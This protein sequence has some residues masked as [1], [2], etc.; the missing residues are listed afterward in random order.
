MREVERWEQFFDA[1]R[2]SRWYLEVE[3]AQNWWWWLRSSRKEGCDAGVDASLDK[4]AWRRA[5]GRLEKEGA[6]WYTC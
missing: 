6:V 5:E 3:D 2:R 4:I 1:C